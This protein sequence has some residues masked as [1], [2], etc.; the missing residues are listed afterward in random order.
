VVWFSV[1]GAGLL[2]L[3]YFGSRVLQQFVS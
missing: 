3:A 1:A 2:T